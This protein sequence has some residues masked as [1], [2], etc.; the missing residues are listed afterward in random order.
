MKTV[1]I[2]DIHGLAEPLATALR[3]VEAMRAEKLVLLGDLLYN[4]P[5]NGKSAAAKLLDAVEIP[6]VAVRGNCDSAADQAALR[7]P[8]MAESAE[9]DLDGRHFFLTHGH[10]QNGSR[11]P[12]LPPGTVIATGH[13]HMAEIRPLP[14]GLTL[15][16]PGSIS[17]PRDGS[18]GTFGVFD[19]HELSILDLETGKPLGT[20]GGWDDE[21]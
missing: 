1:F 7:F 5:R 2:S 14:G 17:L 12:A 19:G 9:I 8:I 10:L 11:H 20:W 15:F 3:H 13:T 16:N 18:F 4:G 21:K 6:V